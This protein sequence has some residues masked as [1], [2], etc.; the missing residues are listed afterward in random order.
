MVWGIVN[1]I[2]Q[3]EFLNAAAADMG[4]FCSKQLPVDSGMC[5]RELKR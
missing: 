2:W 5:Y 1:R 3:I 4:S